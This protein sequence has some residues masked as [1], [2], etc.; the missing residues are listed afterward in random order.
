M[1]DGRDAI[2]LMRFLAGDTD[3]ETGEEIHVHRT[4]SE[5]SGDGVIDEKDLL[6][7]MEF[8]AEREGE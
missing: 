2:R 4:N 1:I 5:C 3:A 6:L 7:I 8:L